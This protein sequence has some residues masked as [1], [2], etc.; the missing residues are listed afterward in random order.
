M[1]T[2][3][4]INRNQTV[5]NLS[6]NNVGTSAETNRTIF[7]ETVAMSVSTSSTGSRWPKI[8]VIAALTASKL[9]SALV[10]K[11]HANACKVLPS[12]LG[13]KE[14]PKKQIY[15]LSHSRPRMAKCFGD[16]VIWDEWQI[17]NVQFR[18]MSRISEVDLPCEELA[19]THTSN[20]R[21]HV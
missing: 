6:M 2:I 5:R 19:N 11:T 9:I 16:E 8:K 3:T 14:V 21:L 7:T 13:H 15:R 18:Y 12:R 1:S 20:G 4:R 17:V 10:P